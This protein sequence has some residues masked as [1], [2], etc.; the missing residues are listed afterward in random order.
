MPKHPQLCPWPR[1]SGLS[2]VALRCPFPVPSGLWD[3][4]SLSLQAGMLACSCFM[5]A[6]GSYQTPG[7]D[8]TAWT[9]LPTAQEAAST[10]YMHGVFLATASTSPMGVMQRGPDSF[11]AHS[12]FASQLGN[13][14]LGE[15]PVLWQAVCKPALCP[16]MKHYHISQGCLLQTQSWEMARGKGGQGLAFLAYPA[17]NERP[18]ENCLSQHTS[19][20]S[21]CVDLPRGLP[22]AIHHLGA[23]CIAVLMTTNNKHKR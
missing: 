2:S 21:P 4:I 15:P 7:S 20:I 11:C 18:M 3:F 9:L 17:R 16:R 23:S 8:F 19:P 22:W 1:S 14:E 5:G 13:T 12:E 10:L 6:G